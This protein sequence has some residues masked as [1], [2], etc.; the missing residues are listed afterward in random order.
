MNQALSL[1]C[2]TFVCSYVL[3]F[4]VVICLNDCI[5]TVVT[6]LLFFFLFSCTCIAF[7]C[8]DNCIILIIVPLFDT[9]LN[10]HEYLN[11]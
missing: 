8:D 9:L 7:L 2:D 10:I 11:K 1:C 4:K 5:Y 3:K 6:C